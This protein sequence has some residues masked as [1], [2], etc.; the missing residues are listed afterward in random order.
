M[1]LDGGI[2]VK[3]KGEFGTWWECCWGFFVSASKGLSGYN[4]KMNCKGFEEGAV[5]WSFSEA[6]SRKLDNQQ[7]IQLL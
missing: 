7:Q 2:C 1:D 6:V 3:L 5:N 4:N